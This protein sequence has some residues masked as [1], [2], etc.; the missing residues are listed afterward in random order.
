MS[1]PEPNSRN[2]FLARELR[3]DSLCDEFEFA[4]RTGSNPLI[5][6]Y[7]K[8]VEEQDRKSLL[9]ELVALEVDF[10]RLQ[11]APPSV[12][13]Y[14]SRFPELTPS[15]VQQILERSERNDST[16]K[17]PVLNTL[18][19]NHTPT[20]G[21]SLS[22]SLAKDRLVRYFGDYEIQDVIAQ[23]G[24]GIVYRARQVSLNRVVALKTILSG[25]FASQ[26]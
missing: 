7:L 5:E 1:D 13:E 22:T 16:A 24:M 15:C 4:F 17:T 8:Q 6:E 18:E 3:I 11:K 25:E 26:E 20:L 23:G 21:E 10:R 2:R 14:L 19:P 12:D 9:L